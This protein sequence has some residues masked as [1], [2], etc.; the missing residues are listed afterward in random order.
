MIKKILLLFK[1][2]VKIFEGDSMIKV[3]VINNDS[4]INII[5]CFNRFVYKIKH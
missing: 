1:K 2:Y 5:T 4:L 3:L